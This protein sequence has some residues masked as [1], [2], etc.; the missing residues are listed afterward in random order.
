MPATPRE[1]LIRAAR[2]QGFDWIPIDILLCDSQVKTF[3]ETYGDID[4]FD[5]FGVDFRWVTLTEHP[6]YQDVRQLFK[7]E[8][9][10]ADTEI[11]VIGV[12]HSK[13]SEAAYHMTR[14]HHPLQGCD[15]L[16]E[17]SAFPLPQFNRQENQPLFDQVTSL[18]QKG[19]AA[20]CAMQMTIWEAAWYIRSMPDL[21]MDMMLED[22]KATV[23]FDR[24]TDYAIR[25]VR[26]YTEAGVDILSMGDDVGMQSGPMMSVELWEKWIKPKFKSVI[27]AAREINPEVLVFYHSCG[28]ATA[29]IPGLIDCGVDILNPIQPECMDFNK[30]HEIYSDRLSFWG[31][32]GTQ[33]LLPFGTPGEVREVSLERI[34]TAGTKGGLILGPTHLVEPEVPF[35]N[36]VA[37][38]NAA[39]ELFPRI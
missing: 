22:E 5:W 24:I 19:L 23:L 1:N 20:M 31:T 10:P 3:K 33:Q 12:G 8:T 11:D 38:K 18:H 39:L 9:L 21:L 26:L 14:M 37:M 30:I 25:R 13:G 2:R 7:R 32:L 29:F 4:Y 36:L 15:S 28:D 35:E 34:R 17:I 6:G 27:D 16:E